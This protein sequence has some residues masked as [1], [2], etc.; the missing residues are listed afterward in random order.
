MLLLTINGMIFF[1]RKGD[2]HIRSDLKIYLAPPSCIIVN[3]LSTNGSN[4]IYVKLS[5]VHALDKNMNNI[6]DI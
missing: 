2:C 6:C 5:C 4:T 1:C 3:T